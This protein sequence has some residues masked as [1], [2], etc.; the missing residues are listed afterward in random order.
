M[1]QLL[2]SFSLDHISPSCSLSSHYF[3]SNRRGRCLLR[4]MQSS[5]KTKNTKPTRKTNK[6]T[7]ENKQTNKKQQTKQKQNKQKDTKKRD[8]HQQCGFMHDD[9]LCVMMLMV[10]NKKQTENPTKTPGVKLE[11]VRS[12]KAQCRNRDP[13]SQ[14]PRDHKEQPFRHDIHP[15]TAL[16]TVLLWLSTI[17]SLAR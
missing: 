17:D 16:R 1:P 12:N 2:L 4:S 7:Q 14:N 15:D 11:G 8:R 3:R 9:I 10:P 13:P 5:K 6:Q